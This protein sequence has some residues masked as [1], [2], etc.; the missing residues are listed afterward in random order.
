MLEKIEVSGY[1]V[2]FAG[3]TLL[4]F[5][6]INAYMFL[7]GILSISV[8]GG[9]MEVFGEALAPLIETCIRAIYL[10]IMGWIGSI[11]TRRG[12]Q[13]LVTPREVAP[14]AELKVKPEAEEIKREVEEIKPKV[15][16]AKAK[17]P[18]RS[19]LRKREKGK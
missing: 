18:S 15:E 10:G 3:V 8:S 14:E 13:I 17:K 2:L 1:T 9:L 5:T 4:A 11:V 12:V 16:K 19:G 7:Q 6:F